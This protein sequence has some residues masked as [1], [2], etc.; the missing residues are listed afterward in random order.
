MTIVVTGAS[1]GIGAATARMVAARGATVVSVARRADRLEA[2]AAECRA[3]AP[4][5]RAWPADLSDPE[6]AGALATA[7]WDEVGP[8]DAWVNNAAIPMRREIRRLTMAEVDRVMKVN[9]Y[10]PVAI[11]L[12]LL[13]KM[14]ARG[15]GTL[16]NVSSLGGRLG[17][18]HEAAYSASKF[19]LCG[20]NESMAADLLGKPVRV[21][22]IIP[23]A[24]DTEIWDQPGNDPPGF[25]GP[26][27]SPDVVAEG[28][29]ASIE[30][31]AFE[32]YVPD[33]RFAVDMKMNDFEG[34]IAGVAAM[35]ATVWKDEAP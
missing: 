19:A 31:D 12:A 33:M 9:Y 32:L 15:S 2:I 26:L 16:V 7:I 21:R 34:F 23:G 5:S 6:E 28:I 22:L 18:P 29:I 20:F 25:T 11:C 24:I 30:G 8:I 13:P 10:S 4:D 35:N 17:I 3:T 1:S 27:A 14:L